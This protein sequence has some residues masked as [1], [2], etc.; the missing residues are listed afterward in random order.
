MEKIS[1]LIPPPRSN[2]IRFHGVLASNSKDRSKV[3]LKKKDNVTDTK[4]D[5]KKSS[6]ISWAKLLP[7]GGVGANSYFVI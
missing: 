3:V 1:S 7:A 5:K 2:I 4:D 6:R